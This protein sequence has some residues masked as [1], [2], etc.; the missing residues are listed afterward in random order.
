[1]KPQF[2]LLCASLCWMGAPC[3][4]AETECPPAPVHDA[5]NLEQLCQDL[6]P[7]DAGPS[8]PADAGVVIP[9]P[10]PQLGEHEV[11]A[12]HNL[13]LGYLKQQADTNKLRPQDRYEANIDVLTTAAGGMVCGAH[14]GDCAEARAAVNAVLAPVRAAA[15]EGAVSDAASLDAFLTAR[16]E[17]KVR[18]GEVPAWAVTQMNAVFEAMLN[19]EKTVEDVMAQI[20]MIGA[21]QGDHKG[22]DQ[23]RVLRSIL[24]SSL[25]FWLAESDG[26]PDPD[27][28]ARHWAA[29]MGKADVKAGLSIGV[30]AYFGGGVTMAGAAAGVACASLLSLW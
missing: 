27:V 4:Q 25:K 18:D 12:V 29:T 19:D 9:E 6:F 26:R 23:G 8:A 5:G 22:G 1:M 30:A 7:H 16:L 2:Y 11:G 14:L 17:Q 15:V 24:T 13:V 10:A 20:A 21:G 3:G 28:Q